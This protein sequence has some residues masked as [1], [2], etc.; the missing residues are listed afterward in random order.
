M[1]KSVINSFLLYLLKIYLKL[2]P[3]PPK[4]QWQVIMLKT[5]VTTAPWPTARFGLSAVDL[6]YSYLRANLNKKWKLHFELR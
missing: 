5:L 4:P 1:C 2:V 3:E 6:F